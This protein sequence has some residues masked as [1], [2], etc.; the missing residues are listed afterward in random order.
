MP[1]G[2][3]MPGLL[4]LTLNAND[5]QCLYSA[6]GRSMADKNANTSRGMCSAFGST[7]LF[8]F[9]SVII[10]FFAM[11]YRVPDCFKIDHNKFD[12]L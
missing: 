5:S 9:P 8:R 4:V 6:L 2:A 10:K 1:R 7:V 11:I 3:I 12:T